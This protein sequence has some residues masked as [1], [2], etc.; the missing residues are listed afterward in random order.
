MDATQGILHGKVI[1][2]TGAASG[3]GRASAL[4]FARQGAAI[5]ACDRDAAVS[6]VADAITG[7][8]GQAVSMT[9]DAGSE[10]DVIAAVDAAVAG[11]GGLDGYFA[12]AGISGGPSGGYFDA[13]TEL[14]AEVLRINVIGPALAVKHAVPAFLK[15][16]GGS[17]VVTA[18]VA[19][20]RAG[21]GPAPYSASKAAA[22]NLVQTAAQAV[23]GTG[24][25]VNGICPGLSETGMT[26]RLYAMARA[27]GQEANLGI[28]NPLRR[29]SAP[30][31][32]ASAALFLFSDMSS[33]VNGEALVV[34]G[35]LASSHP[36]SEMADK[37]KLALID[38]L[39][40]RMTEQHAAG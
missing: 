7:N 18:S 20:L 15:R 29:G 8:G 33:F 11:F 37:Q 27:A 2:I 12:N 5:V 25:R 14:W 30:E 4:M 21:A 13:T 26:S 23:A 16:G 6:A 24:I 31:E 32:I 40:A 19:G 39:R 3:I 1:V 9:M 38:D 22:I 28:R 17:I 36:Y 10:A 35:G 34:D